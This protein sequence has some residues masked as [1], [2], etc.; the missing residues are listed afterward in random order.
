MGP[1]ACISQLS[2]LVALRLSSRFGISCSSDSATIMNTGQVERPR[3][4]VC[5]RPFPGPS[6][7]QEED[8]IVIMVLT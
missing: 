5:V 7:W 1:S 6:G 4:N 3:S 2:S 8:T